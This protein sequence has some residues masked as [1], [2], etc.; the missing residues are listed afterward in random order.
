MPRRNM[1]WEVPVVSE[2]SQKF[3]S[4]NRAP[5]VQIEYDVET[6]GAMRKTEIPFI[7]GVLADLSG[8]SAAELPEI[9]QRKAL[10]IDMDNFDSRLKAKKPSVKFV[11]PNKLT[12]EGN[13]GVELTFESM[14]DFSPAKI[15]SRVE[16]LAK[17]LEARTQLVNL[18]TFMDGR[19]GAEKLISEALRNPALLQALASAPKAAEPEQK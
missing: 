6:N 11:V 4:R 12:H 10:E 16:P 7:M 2:S 5:R 1:S 3:I 18:V 14:E 13:I 9:D 15:A 19:A 17:L 8:V